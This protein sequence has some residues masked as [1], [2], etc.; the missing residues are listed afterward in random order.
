MTSVKIQRKFQG[1]WI[2]AELWLARDLSITEKVMLVE[3]GSLADDARG[4]FASNA[5]FAEFFGLSISRV[6]EIINGLAE[7][8]VVSIEQIRQGKQVVE[9]RIRLLNPFG[10]PKTPSENAANPFGKGEEPPSEKAKGS[11]TKSSNTL[12]VSKGASAQ[13]DGR[14]PKFDPMTSKPLNVSEEAWEGFVMMRKSKSKPL[15]ARAC[16]LIAKKLEGR[17]DAD[18]IVD[19]STANSWTDVYPES[20]GGA[21]PS[22]PSA[23]V[24]LPTH[25]PE[26]YQDQEAGNGAQF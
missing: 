8:K 21:K 22:R 11:N 9:R 26:M 25:T 7:K 24:G 16:Q 15:T 2:P 5:H 14:E 13:G 18:S 10:K 19:R 20:A 4:C 3:I 6:S 1:V 23:Y 12:R 17:A